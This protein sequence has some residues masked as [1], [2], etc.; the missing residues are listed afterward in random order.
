MS[1]ALLSIGTAVPGTAF[2][3]AEGLA[4]ADALHRPTAEQATW[5]PGIYRGTGI[6]RRHSVLPR[7]LINDLLAGTRASES[8][9]LPKR[10]PADS[11]PTTAQRLACYSEH[12]IPLACQASR[13]T[14]AQSGLAAQRI[15]HL[16][17]VSCTGF[18]APGWDVA[19]ID[20]LSLPPTVERTH[21]GFMGCH[22]ALNGLRVARAFVD[23]DPEACVLLCATELCTLHYHYHWDPE[24]TVANA[25]FADGAAALVGAHHSR[26]PDQFWRLTASGAAILPNSI[27][28]MTWRIGD[29]GFEM[30]LSKDVP[31][32]IRKHLLPTLQSWLQ[33]HNLEVG[34]VPSWAIHPGGPKIVAQV[35]EA[36]SL[37]SAQIADS[38]AVLAAFGN[39]SSPTILF[40]LDR[41]R[42]YAAK[43]PCVALGFGPGLALECALLE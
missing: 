27:D 30:S 7:A 3:Q 29:H 16:V 20:Q 2:D 4:M 12:A 35:A 1:L 17:T 39:M 15:T 13:D 40:V 37:T 34:R 26:A 32:L 38:L 11:G 36:L 22:G 10:S 31:H 41:L 6:D 43:R 21:I 33:R 24:K 5:L 19:L 23:A 18:S 8:I 14:L 9:F 28:A 42:R 25:L